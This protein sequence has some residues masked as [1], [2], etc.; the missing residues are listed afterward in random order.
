MATSQCI[1]LLN[2]SKIKTLPSF[3]KKRDIVIKL[4]SICNHKKKSKIREKKNQIAYF[5]CTNAPM[6]GLS[7]KKKQKKMKLI[8]A[9]KNSQR[10]K[11]FFFL[12]IDNNN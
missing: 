10:E 2:K 7:K 1:R 4:I 3:D 12:H 8:G 6:D 9:K 11:K 5:Q